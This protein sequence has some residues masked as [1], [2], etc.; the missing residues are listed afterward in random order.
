MMNSEI[1]RNHVA[2]KKSKFKI[3]KDPTKF[4]KFQMLSDVPNEKKFDTSGSKPSGLMSSGLIHP[5]EFIQSKVIQS[6]KIQAS[7]KTEH[8]LLQ[9]HRTGQH[10][11][12]RLPQNIDHVGSQMLQTLGQ[13][14]IDEMIDVLTDKFN[15]NNRY[16]NRCFI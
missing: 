14:D 9:V 4:K 10:V 16:S 1:K 12:L 11:E 15:K 2:G 3:F 5:S 7:H 13:E 8:V 6:E